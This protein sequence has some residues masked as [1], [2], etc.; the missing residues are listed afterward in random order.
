MAK[1]LFHNA[2]RAALQ[3][4]NWIITDDPLKIEAGGAKFEIDLGVE[5]LLAADRGQEKIA[6]EIKTFA[7]ESLITDYHAALGQFLNYRLALELNGIDRSLYLA[8]PVLVYEA[9]FQKEFLQI[10]VER[11]K[12][13]LIIYEPINEV[14]E[15]WIN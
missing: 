3:K 6:I 14:I 5:R 11:Y 1:D 7:G 12:I 13:Q 9:F 15:Q 4:E 10:S 8:V 2:V